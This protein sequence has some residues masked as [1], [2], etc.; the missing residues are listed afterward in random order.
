MG[1]GQL[2]ANREA[3]HETIKQSTQ[4]RKQSKQNKKT[5]KKNIKNIS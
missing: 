4:N 2:Y 3:I 1:N 5:N